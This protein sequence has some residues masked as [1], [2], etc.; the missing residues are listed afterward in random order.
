MEYPYIWWVCVTINKKNFSL[1]PSLNL[2]DHFTL[3]FALNLSYLILF[4]IIFSFFQLFYL[5]KLSAMSIF[6]FVLLICFIS[7]DFLNL[8]FTIN[9]NISFSLLLNYVRYC[10][11]IHCIFSTQTPVIKHLHCFHV[12]AIANNDA[13]S[14]VKPIVIWIDGFLFFELKPKLITNLRISFLRKRK[15]SL[16]DKPQNNFTKAIIIYF[17]THSHFI[18][19]NKSEQYFKTIAII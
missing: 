1:P 4:S 7:Q 5:V 9:G 11:L 15:A 10:E 13:V 12:Q 14:T 6:V 16:R 3:P 8:I 19:T 2:L 18:L 17:S